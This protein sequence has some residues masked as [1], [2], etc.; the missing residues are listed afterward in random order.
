MPEAPPA[1]PETKLQAEIAAK[2]TA[3]VQDTGIDA[4]LEAEFQSALDADN[5]RADAKKTGKPE[6]ATEPA[7]PAAAKAEPAAPAAK[8][9]LDIPEALL[10]DKKVETPKDTTAADAARQKDIEEGVK[11]LSPKAADRFRAL[12]AKKH[13]A[14]QKAARVGELEKKLADTEKRLT[15]QA[16]ASEMDRYKKQVEELDAIV[17]KTALS[18]HPKFKAH[19]DVQIEKEI[20]GAAK[21]L[22]GDAAKEAKALLSVPESR[23]RNKRLG[24]L[25]QELE[26]LEATKFHA[27]VDRADRLTAEKA[28]ELTNWRANKDRMAQM[29]K[30]EQAQTT[31]QRQRVIDT[32]YKAVEKK[33]SDPEKGIELFRK[34]DGNDEWNKSV[35]ER[36]AHV[37]KLTEAELRPDDVA[38]MAAWAMSGAEY[39]KLFLSQR[40]LVQKLQQEIQSLKGGEPDLGEAGG[41]GDEVEEGGM[42]DVVSRTAQRAGAVR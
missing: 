3:A 6:P 22:S 38:E 16:D 8:P 28:H 33:F 32:A 10:G 26:P 23:E 13:E 31:E 35:E 39:R 25:A 12:E 27:A 37:R 21:F 30:D 34:V 15:Q 2:T 1:A 9:T 11:G 24:E 40:V 29:S 5:A 4:A 41:A 17:Q 42:I 19:Y 20:E 7:K 14:E 36:L 18:D